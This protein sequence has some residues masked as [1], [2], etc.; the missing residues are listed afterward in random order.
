LRC[1]RDRLATEKARPWNQRS[2]GGAHRG[3]QKVAPRKHRLPHALFPFLE[4]LQASRPCETAYSVS[5]IRKILA[6]SRQLYRRDVIESLS[7]LGFDKTL[8][9]AAIFSALSRKAPFSIRKPNLAAA[10][11]EIREAMFHITF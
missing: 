9:N 3:L 11:N 7:L 10:F 1:R 8:A 6:G 2:A 5:I 4:I